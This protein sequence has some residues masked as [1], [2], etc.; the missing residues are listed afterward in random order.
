MS[1]LTAIV[2][3]GECNSWG[4]TKAIGPATPPAM[5]TW[6]ALC[7]WAR[8]RL[9]AQVARWKT[10]TRRMGGQVLNQMISRYDQPPGSMADI[11]SSRYHLQP[12]SS[13]SLQTLTVT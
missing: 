7:V 8:I 3:Y 6:R 13:A 9:L 5:Q 11:K 1:V 12:I 10:R 4:V 2:S